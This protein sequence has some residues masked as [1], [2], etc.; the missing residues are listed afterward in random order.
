VKSRDDP[1]R[2]SLETLRGPRAFLGRI[3][4]IG[5]LD[6]M[7]WGHHSSSRNELILWRIFFGA[8]A[9]DYDSRDIITLL[10]TDL[11]LFWAQ[12]AIGYSGRS[13]AVASFRFHHWR[14]QRSYLAQPRSTPISR[15]IFVVAHFFL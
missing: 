9:G 6:Y 7:V 13:S 4:A 12:D 10:L 15:H 14:N 11:F 5:L 2:G 8:H 1:A 3:G